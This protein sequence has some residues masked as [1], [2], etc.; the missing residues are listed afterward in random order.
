V[1]TIEEYLKEKMPQEGVLG[2]DGRV[3]NTS[4]GEELEALLSEKEVAITC[5]ED[6][7]DQIWTERPE[8]S[9]KPVW[10][11]DER[12]AGKS[13]KDKIRELREDMKRERASVHILTTL[14]DIAWLLNIRGNDIACN[15]MVLSYAMITEQD[16]Y[17]YIHSEV[18][19]EEVSSYLKEQGVTVKEYEEIYTMV[20]ELRNE[21]ILLEKGCT[22]YAIYSSIDHSNDVIDKI[23]PTVLKKAIKNPTEVENM[24]KAHLKDGVAMVKFIRWLKENIGKIPM[25]EMSVS[26]YLDQLR[27]EQEGNLGLSF[28]TIS[29]YG[30]HA[31]MCHYSATEETNV[32]IEAKGL[33]LVDSGGQYYE[34]TTDVTRTIAVGE[35]TKEE[36]EH[37][38]LT[39]MSMLRLGAVKFLYGCRGLTLDYVARE[40]FWSRGLNYDHGT[41]HGVGFLANVHERPN[42][43]RW[44]MVQERQDHSVFEEGMVTSNEPGIYIAGSHGVRTENLIVCKKAEKNEYGQFMEFEYL[45]MVPIDL[46]AI[47][48]TIMT[49]RDITLLNAYH[50]EVYEKLSPYLNEEE[51]MW[52]QQATRAIHKD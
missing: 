30:P 14:D 26:K 2:F 44:K 47:D 4:M 25:D 23:N 20:S 50:K 16:F 27:S 37:F 45:T 1:P 24:K 13:A 8:I 6:L 36:K 49:E 7:I 15:P 3:M 22:N 31:A 19:N 9:K 41:G 39:V 12:F 40:P 34:G 5:K 11:L 48:P 18:I 17:L 33:Y 43:I 29:A 10:I 42:G 52:L 28:H 51:K 35:L 38:T 32:P 46:D 21:T